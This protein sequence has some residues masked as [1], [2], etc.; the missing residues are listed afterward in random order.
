ME[1][2][3]IIIPD[4]EVYENGVARSSHTYLFKG[5]LSDLPAGEF[6]DIALGISGTDKGKVGFYDGTAWVEQ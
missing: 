4:A 5:S 1:T 2:I 3:F 6:G